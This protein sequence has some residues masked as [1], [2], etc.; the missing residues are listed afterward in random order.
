VHLKGKVYDITTFIASHP[1]GSE[2]IKL[3]AGK[4][5]E[6]FWALYKQ[7]SLVTETRRAEEC[8]ATNPLLLSFF[9]ENAPHSLGEALRLKNADGDPLGPMCWSC[10]P[11]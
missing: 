11:G 8:E 1:G 9:V 4:G 6:P 2:K 10:G 7:V 3:A 5:V